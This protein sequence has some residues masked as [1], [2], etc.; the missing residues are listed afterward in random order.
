MKRSG[1]GGRELVGKSTLWPNASS[2]FVS[3]QAGEVWIRRGSK[4]QA[5]DE[6]EAD[7]VLG[8]ER[9]DAGYQAEWIVD[10]FWPRP[11]PFSRLV[12]PPSF[13]ALRLQ[14]LFSYLKQL[15]FPSVFGHPTPLKSPS[16][17]IWHRRQGQLS[18][19]HQVQFGY[20][21]LSLDRCSF[22]RAPCPHKTLLPRVLKT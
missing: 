3:E 18:A 20:S 14:L 2:L 21:A 5:Q 6:L 9:Y 4:Q 8:G 11:F 10:F 19:L 13:Y 15:P 16:V 22:R 7:D 1:H 12:P 17:S